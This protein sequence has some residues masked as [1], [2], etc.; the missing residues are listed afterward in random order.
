MFIVGNDAMKEMGGQAAAARLLQI[1]QPSVS[2]KARLTSVSP[3]RSQVK[4]NKRS[5]AFKDDEA[6]LAME[7]HWVSH[8]AVTFFR[9]I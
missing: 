4:R 6:S 8:T 9:K 5:D 3:P 2:K 1:K 7:A